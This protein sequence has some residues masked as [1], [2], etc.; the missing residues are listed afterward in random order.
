M[1]RAAALALMVAA[2]V[3]WSSAGVV[4]RHIERAEAIEQVFWRSFFAFLF[5]TIILSL[6][7][8]PWKA[9]RNAGLPGLFSGVLW[10]VMFTAFVIALSLTTTANTLVMMSIAPLLTVVCARI[11]LT[12]PIPLRTW[13]AAL[14]A[15]AGIAIMFS[16]SMESHAAGMLVALVIPVASALNVVALR[17]H[18]TTLDLIPAV[19]LGGALSALVAL[20]LAL[21]ISASGKDLALLAFLGV[22]QLGLPCMFLVM[23]SRALLAPEIALL[24][25]LE[26][27][28]GPLWAWLGAGETPATSTLIGGVLVLIALAGNEIAAFRVRKGRII[29][30]ANPLH[31]PALGATRKG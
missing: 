5:V 15:M 20:P 13:I 14:A 23:A 27:V 2:P 29:I 25:L 18:S 9:L 10:A 7:G 6:R 4:T 1:T 19:M 3:L 24:G 17:K 28:L 16:S 21:P 26:V 8:G 22:L 12:D 31:A 30:E 11:V